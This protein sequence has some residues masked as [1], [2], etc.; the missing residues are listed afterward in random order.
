MAL[1]FTFQQ[2][3]GYISQNMQCRLTFHIKLVSFKNVDI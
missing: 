1:V 3:V 2:K